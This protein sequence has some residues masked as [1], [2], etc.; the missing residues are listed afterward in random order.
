MFLLFFFFKHKTA[1]EMRI[2]DWSS[3]VCSSDL[4]ADRKELEQ[5]AG[6]FPAVQKLRKSGYDGRGVFTINSTD[7]LPVAFNEPS[8]LEERVDFEKELSVLVARNQ[9][10]EVATYDVAET[11]FNSD[12]N[13]VEILFS[14]ARISPAMAR[15][16]RKIP[17]RPTQKQNLLGQLA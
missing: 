6:K 16:A 12:A 15:E 5:H 10:G 17:L 1:Y 13:L 14:P 2:S 7:D 4:I 11:E 3:D 8:I 9:S